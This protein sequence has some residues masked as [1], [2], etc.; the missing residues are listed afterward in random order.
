MLGILLRKVRGLNMKTT[1]W[2]AERTLQ[3]ETDP[4]AKVEVSL[5]YP[6]QRTEDEWA[7]PFRIV[8]LDSEISEYGIGVDALQ[9]LIMAHEGVATALRAS[10][11][12]LSWMGIPGETCI[13]RQIPVYINADFANE[14]EAHIDAKLEAFVEAKQKQLET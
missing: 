14:I 5:G 1:K 3:D 13:R 2:L 12:K 7:C 11:R 4:S 9:A 6:E 8:G 10:K